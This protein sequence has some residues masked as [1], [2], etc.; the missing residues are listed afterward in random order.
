M[1]RQ[2]YGACTL[3]RAGQPQALQGSQPVQLSA[4][5]EVLALRWKHGELSQAV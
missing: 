1:G 4:D 5:D 3:Q 2:L